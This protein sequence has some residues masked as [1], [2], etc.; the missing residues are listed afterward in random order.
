[1]LGRV[2]VAKDL[3]L[4]R[5]TTK[6][7]DRRPI[8]LFKFGQFVPYIIAKAY[9]QHLRKKI[10]LHFCPRNRQDRSHLPDRPFHNLRA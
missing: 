1:M 2:R 5:M 4:Y 6:V 8:A 3:N 7:S 10:V 9:N